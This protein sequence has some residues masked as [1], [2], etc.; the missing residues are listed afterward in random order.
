MN[1]KTRYIAL[2]NS[3][4]YIPLFSHYQWLALFP[5][6][7]DVVEFENYF[8]AIVIQK[9][10][11]FNVIR[12]PHFSPY[13]SLIPKQNIYIDNNIALDKS[14]IITTIQKETGVKNISLEFHPSQTEFIKTNENKRTHILDL[15]EEEIS[16][17]YKPSLTRQI[18]KAE[19]KL[20][21]ALSDDFKIVEKLQKLSLARQNKKYTMPEGLGEK[22]FSYCAQEDK[23]KLLIAS[24][25]K[26]IHAALWIVYDKYYAYYLFGG[27]D[28]QFLGSGAMGLLLHHALQFCKSKE[29]HFFDFEGSMEPS[30]ARF[31]KTFNAKEQAYPFILSNSKSFQFLQ[32]IKP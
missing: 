29:L 30:I 26:N 6:D 21:V 4:V 3:E 13:L 11:G 32:K 7:W 10:Y 16:K 12:N 9:R 8:L 25:N 27:S 20:S 18:K 31:F 22:L 19:K 17:N 2:C 1:K 28:P 15:R 24:E 14:K 23:G 5:Y